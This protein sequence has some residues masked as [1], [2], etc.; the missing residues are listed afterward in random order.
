ML[1]NI[2]EQIVS[3]IAF[4]LGTSFVFR[5]WVQAI[6]LRPPNSLG[7]FTFVMTDWLVHPLR[8]VIPGIGGYDWASLVGALLIAILATLAV[9]VFYPIFTIQSLLVHSLLRVIDW[10]IYG[11]IIFLILEV[12]FSWINP[13][14]PMAPFVRALN[15]PLLRPIQRIIPPIGGIDFSCMIALVLL[16]IVSMV[17]HQLIPR[18]A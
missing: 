13:Q 9:V 4:V 11:L 12:V 7:S 18:L 15:A 17:A 2:Y 1:F 10:L 16:Q 8:R 5:F 6:R 3:A 14:A